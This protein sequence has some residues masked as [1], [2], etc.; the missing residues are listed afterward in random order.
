MPYESPFEGSSSQ[1]YNPADAIASP[2][3]WHD[4]DGVAGPEFNTTQGNNAFA[5]ADLVAPDGFTTGD[6]TTT[7]TAGQT[8]TYTADFNQPPTANQDAAITNL[9]YVTNRVHDILYHYGFDEAS[10]NFQSNN[11]GN[12]GLENDAVKAEAQDYSGIN[13]ANFSTP[14]DGSQP[15]MQMYLGSAALTFTVN[16]PISIAG[17]IDR[18]GA[19]FGPLTFDVS[20]DVALIDDGDTSDGGTTTDGCQSIINNISGKIA[21]L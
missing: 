5:Y 16:S 18:I 4:S 20:G 2:Y 3:G 19:S 17:E 7:A 15:R 1:V 10:G 14:S 6:A 13:N 8:F 11:Y 21:L 9:F 12:G